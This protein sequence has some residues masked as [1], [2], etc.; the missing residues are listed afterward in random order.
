MPDPVLNTALIGDLVQA[1]YQ[2]LVVLINFHLPFIILLASSSL[3]ISS[4]EYKFIY[5]SIHLF[6]YLPN[7]Y[8]CSW[9]FA[10]S[11]LP[12]ILNVIKYLSSG[13]SGSNWQGREVIYLLLK[14]VI[15]ANQWYVWILC[16]REKSPWLS[17]GLIRKDSWE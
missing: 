3:W 17:I 14:G 8:L 2:M 4:S 1:L 10:K 13:N 5:P 15:N 12:L 6:I 16:E 11:A 9:Y 7:K